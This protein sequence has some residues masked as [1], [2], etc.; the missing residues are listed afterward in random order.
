M[1]MFWRASF[2]VYGSF[3]ASAGLEWH[4]SSAQNLQSL[5]LLDVR[6]LA[7]ISSGLMMQ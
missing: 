6:V 1:S 3:D 7:R 4:K 2:A 5:E